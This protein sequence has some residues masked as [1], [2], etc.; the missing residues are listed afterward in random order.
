MLFIVYMCTVTSPIPWLPVLHCTTK[1]IWK[2]AI[3]NGMHLSYHHLLN[4]L[5]QGIFEY[6]EFHA[7]VR[8][9]AHCEYASMCIICRH[10]PSYNKSSSIHTSP[11]LQIPHSLV[12]KIWQKV[13]KV[14]ASP[15]KWFHVILYA[16]QSNRFYWLNIS[17]MHPICIGHRYF[18]Y[19]VGDLWPYRNR[20]INFPR[21]FIACMCNCA[22]MV[23]II[24]NRHT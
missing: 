19:L 13:S 18:A 12:A 11:R 2:S 22:N 3:G 21:Q 17:K 10:I 14:M 1:I 6:G 4:E 24:V 8:S 20:P 7:V 9:V 15:H 5:S 23:C 16:F